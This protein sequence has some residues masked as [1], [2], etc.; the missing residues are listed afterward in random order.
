MRATVLPSQPPPNAEQTNRYVDRLCLSEHMQGNLRRHLLRWLIAYKAEGKY[1]AEPRPI[2]KTIYDDFY[3]FAVEHSHGDMP[4]DT[5]ASGKGLFGDLRNA[6]KAYYDGPGKNDSIIIL[7]QGGK[8][9]GYEPHIEWNSRP[10]TN[11][12]DFDLEPENI[13]D[14]IIGDEYFIF[15][16]EAKLPEDTTEIWVAAPDLSNVGDGSKF[17]DRVRKIVRSNAARGINYTYLCPRGEAGQ[18]RINS[19]RDC[20]VG[21]PGKLKLLQISVDDFCKITLVHS[22]FKSFNPKAAEPEAYMQL[23]VAHAEKGWVKLN[24]H[25]AARVVKKLK[26]FIPE[27][28]PR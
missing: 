4:T 19:L 21:T 17:S 14:G 6:L 20:F 28:S 23:P 26:E 12:H 22:H 18:S 9:G 15:Q 2:A 7:L 1:N 5:E 3:K 10:A 24:R 11:A 16:I 8:G 13:E 25:D 27:D